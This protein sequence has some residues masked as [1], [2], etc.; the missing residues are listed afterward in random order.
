VGG[1]VGTILPDIDHILYL[2]LKPQELTTQ[3][4]GFLLSKYDIKRTFGLLY[5]TR[6]ERRDLIF[7]TAFFQVIF[8]ILTFWMLTSSGSYF[9][10]GLVLAFS[11][12][13]LVD[14][15]I[16][17]TELRSFEN[18]QKLSPWSFDLTK[19]KS[20]WIIVFLLVCVFGFLL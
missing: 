19:A 11:L 4:V 2:Y 3:R 14:Q 13:L 17:L 1:I 8:M 16:D 6:S 7:H 10:R 12:H 20:Y 5:E 15:M 9:G 18:W